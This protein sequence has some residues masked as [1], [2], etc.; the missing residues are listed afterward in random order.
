M[1]QKL[2]IRTDFPALWYK[3]LLKRQEEK[4]KMRMAEL[5]KV[6][7]ALDNLDMKYHWD[8]AYLFGSLTKKGRFIRNSD[9]DIGVQGLN[10]LDHYAFVGDISDLLDRPVDVVLLEECHFAKTIKKKGQDKI[11][12]FLAEFDYQS[13]RLITFSSMLELSLLR[14]FV[15]SPPVDSL[16]IRRG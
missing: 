15:S 4:E 3:S 13:N 5:Q 16:I 1:T 9:I 8:E 7:E 2:K 12:V 14:T 6:E 10:K 11:V